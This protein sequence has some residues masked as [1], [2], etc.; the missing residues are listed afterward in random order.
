M[1]ALI[2]YLEA[3]DLMFGDSILV[4]KDQPAFIDSRSGRMV[5]VGPAGGQCYELSYVLL[6]GESPWPDQYIKAFG[7]AE[8]VEQCAAMLKASMAF[9][10][11][12]PALPRKP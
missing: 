5:S 11:E 12:H 7:M 10:A 4:T 8:D 2:D 9:F 1:L 6:P 3:H